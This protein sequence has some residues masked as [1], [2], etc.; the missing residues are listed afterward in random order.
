MKFYQETTN[1]NDLYRPTSAA[2]GTASDDAAVRGNLAD[3]M[4]YG[5]LYKPTF[6]V[7]QNPRQMPGIIETTS[8]SAA[9]F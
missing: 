6:Y 7:Q 9:S 2:A 5:T 1:A 3:I 8:T 4:R